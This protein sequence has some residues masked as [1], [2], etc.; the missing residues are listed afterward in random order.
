[1]KICYRISS[2]F[3]WRQNIQKWLL[4]VICKRHC[5]KWFVCYNSVSSRL[6]NSRSPGERALNENVWSRDWRFSQAFLVFARGIVPLANQLFLPGLQCQIDRLEIVHP[7]VFGQISLRATAS[8]PLEIAFLKTSAR[9]DYV[10]VDRGWEEASREFR[11][12]RKSV[13]CLLRG[14][15]GLRRFTIYLRCNFVRLPLEVMARCD[16]TIDTRRWWMDVA[17]VRAA[18]V[19]RGSAFIVGECP[20]SRR[21]KK[22]LKL[23]TVRRSRLISMV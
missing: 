6:E 5:R 21:S 2:P 17:T 1:M 18:E 20:S 10:R 16:S 11:S 14:G 23:R 9:R 3:F 4:I 12:P 15:D 8:E 22:A 7:Q 13:A 19:G